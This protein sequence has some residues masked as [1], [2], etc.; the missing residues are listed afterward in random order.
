MGFDLDASIAA[1]VDTLERTQAFYAGLPDAEWAG[2]TE[3]PGWSVQDLASHVIA[4]ERDTLGDPAP[5]HV[6]DWAALPHAADPVSRYT[7]VGV[8]LRRARTPEE[9]RAELAAVIDRRKPDLAASPREAEA[10]VRGPAGMAAP[11]SRI[12]PMR[13]FDVWAHLQDARRATGRPGDLDSPG[14]Q[15]TRDRLLRA[16]GILLSKELAAPPGTTVRVTVD[17]ALAFD[18]DLVVGPDGRGAARP[19]EEGAAGAQISTD[20]ESFVRLCCGR[21][22]LDALPIRAAGDQGLAQRLLA[23]AAIT[24]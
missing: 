3:L 21:A 14:G 16:L 17:G 15:V 24:P 11:A 1:Y 7:E 10:A 22:P 18:V 19:A 2:P 20:W 13:T 4:I 12:Y 23:V 9:I 5:D 8:D 6:P